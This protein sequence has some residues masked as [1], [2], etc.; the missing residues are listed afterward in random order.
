MT[1]S[2]LGYL[3]F[4]Q[5]LISHY[6]LFSIMCRLRHRRDYVE[7]KAVLMRSIITWVAKDKTNWR[8]GGPCFQMKNVNF[9]RAAQ[10]TEGRA[11]G[12]RKR[13]GQAAEKSKQLWPALFRSQVYYAARRPALVYSPLARPVVQPAGPPFCAAGSPRK[14]QVFHLATRPSSPPGPPFSV[15]QLEKCSYAKSSEAY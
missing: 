12:L 2:F 7:D 6:I 10:K 8:A 11:G 5:T 9:R 13:T 4:E 3:V 1:L 14:I 15:I